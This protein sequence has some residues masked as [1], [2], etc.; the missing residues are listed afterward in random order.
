[1]K[2]HAICLALVLS[3][4]GA[5][6]AQPIRP[7]NQF[8]INLQ[9]N[10]AGAISMV[11]EIVP[12]IDGL[13][14]SEPVKPLPEI[15]LRDSVT[16]KTL[17]PTNSIQF[18]NTRSKIELNVL[19]GPSLKSFLETFQKTDQV[20]IFLSDSLKMLMSDNSILA[21]LPAKMKA[22]SAR[23]PFDLSPAQK[24]SLIDAKSGYISVFNNRLDAGLRDAPNDTTDISS[25]IDFSFARPLFKNSYA[26]ISGL[27]T[28]D[29]TDR[30]AHVKLTPFSYRSIARHTLVFN[31]YLQASLDGRQTRMAAALFYSGIVGNFIDMTKGFNRLQP[32]PIVSA[33]VNMSYYSNSADPDFDKEL[34]AEPFVELLYLI[35]VMDNYTLHID[36]YA[37]W[38]S[39]NK[40][41]FDRDNA[42]WS[43]NIAL[44]YQLDGTAQVVGKYSYGRDAF[45]REVDNRLML[46]FLLST[47]EQ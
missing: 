47:F 9:I 5:A 2:K 42:H 44:S 46:G 40:L 7:A 34:F 32:K 26:E 25:Y 39:D 28:S 36:M 29:I 10:T 31:S 35:P 11:I 6:S 13:R 30:L 15:E 1:M 27:L 45:T 12:A 20:Y 3:L 18:S 24:D 22:V 33:G 43:W 41:K 37:F 19:V 23:Q 14:F 8:T 21:F 38:R 17:V 16:D 4:A